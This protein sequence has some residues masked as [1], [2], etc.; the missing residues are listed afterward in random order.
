M[1]Q[2]V[3]AARTCGLREA[4]GETATSRGICW[5]MMAAADASLIV[6]V[7]TSATGTGVDL[8]EPFRSRLVLGTQA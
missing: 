4:E 5:R 7:L 3:L 1:C 6:W 8:R 2:N